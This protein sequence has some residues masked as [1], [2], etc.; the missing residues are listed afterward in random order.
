MRMRCRTVLIRRR[1]TMTSFFRRLPSGSR[2]SKLSRLPEG[3]CSGDR[4][5]DTRL[6]ASSLTALIRETIG[7]RDLRR[8][9]VR[10]YGPTLAPQKP[11]IDRD[12]G[13]PSR[14]KAKRQ[15]LEKTAGP[16]STA[17]KFSRNLTFLGAGGAAPYKNSKKCE[18]SRFGP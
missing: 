3:Q 14:D 17:P 16:T 18:W 10:D 9:R 7:R 6:G 15:S 8:P 13:G 5:S 2:Q 11:Q 12:E 4:L 1:S